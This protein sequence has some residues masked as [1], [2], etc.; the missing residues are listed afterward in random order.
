M[1]HLSVTPG[2]PEAMPAPDLYEQY[3]HDHRDAL[4]QAVL[5]QSPW[6]Q[7]LLHASL[8]AAGA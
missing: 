5:A 2:I 4:R 6:S 8:E 3:V 1:G 7:G